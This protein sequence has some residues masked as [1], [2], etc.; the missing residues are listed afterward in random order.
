[1]EGSRSKD[2]SSSEDKH[3]GGV[4]GRM[5]SFTLRIPDGELLFISSST[6]PYGKLTKRM[7]MLEELLEKT[8]WIR[9]DL[10]Y[11]E[12]RDWNTSYGIIRII[13]KHED[14]LDWIIDT[15]LRSELKEKLHWK[16]VQ[17][18]HQLYM[19]WRQ[20]QWLKKRT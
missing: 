8:R 14:N 3:L 17:K 18:K 7:K 2:R 5:E 6:A 12:G 11:R 9:H 4:D 19:D 1:M 15:P 13:S 16:G 10:N 20:E